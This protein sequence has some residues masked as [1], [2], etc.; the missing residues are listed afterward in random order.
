MYTIDIL[1]ILKM[2]STLESSLI[3][4]IYGATSLLTCFSPFENV[5]I[6]LAEINTNT[7]IFV[8]FKA[9][10]TFGFLKDKSM[11]AVKTITMIFLI[12]APR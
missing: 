6:D 7:Y 3:Y 5:A 2:S 9:V 11:Y 1:L 4:N 10:H 12:R 8:I